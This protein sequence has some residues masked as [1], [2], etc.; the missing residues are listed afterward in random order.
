MFGLFGRIAVFLGATFT[1]NFLGFKSV[2]RTLMV[3]T[4][5]IVL[6]N[7]GVSWV[8]ESLNWGIGKLGSIGAPSTPGG[9]TTNYTGVCGWFLSVL[10]VPECLSFISTVVVSKYLIRLVG[11]L[12]LR[13]A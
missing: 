6:Y 5:G 2:A 11:G 1:K 12:F 10:R 4:L 13:G 3:V 8:E 7:F 9:I